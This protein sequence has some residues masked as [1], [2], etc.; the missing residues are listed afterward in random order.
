[1]RA[2]E[3]VDHDVRDEQRHAADD[4]GN[5]QRQRTGGLQVLPG[6]DLSL[7]ECD[8]HT[9]RRYPD[10]QP[11]DDDSDRERAEVLRGDEASQHHHR[12]HEHDLAADARH[13][14]PGQTAGGQL[15]KL[16]GGPTL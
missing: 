11:S 14:H 3:R 1:M 5:Q 15:G 12:Q 16:V 7:Y 10:G 9:V 6:H 8:S 4:G 2:D 13:R